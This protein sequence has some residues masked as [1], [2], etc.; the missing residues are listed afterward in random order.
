[1]PGA[2]VAALI[3]TPDGRYLMQHRDDLPFIFF[4]GFWGLFGGA[5]EAG[6]A[7]EATLRRELEEE[8]ELR[9]TRFT[10]FATTVLDFGFAGYGPLERHFFEV[11]IAVEDVS[12][13]V[14]G[15]GQGMA[16]REA[17]EV[18][19]A[20]MIVPYDATAIWQ[21]AARDRFSSSAEG[22]RKGER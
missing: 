11:P 9:P 10:H 16:L 6:E 8:L 13:M 3:V 18:L 17:D 5:M 15:E 7:P 19:G 12:A 4:P 1:M 14:L 22:A 21:H 2:A 20:A